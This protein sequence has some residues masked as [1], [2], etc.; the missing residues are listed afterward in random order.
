MRRLAGT[1][2]E[3]ATVRIEPVAEPVEVEVAVRAIHVGVRHVDVATRI[4]P[5]KY[6]RYL[7]KHHPLNI[8]LLKVR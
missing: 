1:G 4:R 8:T 6:T 5:P 7:P 3:D 2:D